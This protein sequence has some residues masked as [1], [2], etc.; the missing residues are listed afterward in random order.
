M[1]RM[2]KSLA[3]PVIKVKDLLL[4]RTALMGSHFAGIPCSDIQSGWKFTK[5]LMKIC[6]IF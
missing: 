2:Q 4:N 3:T 5:L 1:A 6:K